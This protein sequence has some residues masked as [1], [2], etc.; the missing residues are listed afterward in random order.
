M[1]SLLSEEWQARF[2]PWAPPPLSLV[3]RACNSLP[4]R[5]E[6]YASPRLEARGVSDRSHVTS[7]KGRVLYTPP[8]FV[9]AC[10]IGTSAKI[11]R[12]RCRK[13]SS[14]CMIRDNLTWALPIFTKS[15]RLPS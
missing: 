3:R 6:Q 5:G 11:K 14:P 9:P 2:H 12:A 8:L 4:Y 1:H 13:H 15:S 7:F 10:Q